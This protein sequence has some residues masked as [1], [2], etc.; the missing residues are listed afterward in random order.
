MAVLEPRCIAL[1]GRRE[2]H[3]A[4]VGKTEVT[5]LL[6]TYCPVYTR[7]CIYVGVNCRVTQTRT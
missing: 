5:E 4:G 6:L 2:N 7:Q 1:H 3:E